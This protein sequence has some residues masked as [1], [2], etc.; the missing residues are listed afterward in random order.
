MR[1]LLT[2]VVEAVRE[3]KKN[4]LMIGLLAGTV[5]FAALSILI[6]LWLISILT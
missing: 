6:S 1:W 2:D 3:P 5:A 4:L